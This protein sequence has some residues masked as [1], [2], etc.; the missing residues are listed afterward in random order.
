MYIINLTRFHR[1]FG[2]PSNIKL[3]AWRLTYAIFGIPVEWR[4]IYFFVFD[5]NPKRN[6]KQ[7]YDCPEFPLASVICVSVGFLWTKDLLWRQDRHFATFGS[8]KIC[9][10]Q[11]LIDP[12]SL[13]MLICINYLSLNPFKKSICILFHILS[14]VWHKATNTN[15][16]VLGLTWTGLCPT[17]YC[18]QGE[19]ANQFLLI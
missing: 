17:I 3:F 8:L 4:N 14:I 15:F 9:V 5:W 12:L 13:W 2:R 18:T 19:D 11:V 10:V 16:L 1:A 7:N 6:T